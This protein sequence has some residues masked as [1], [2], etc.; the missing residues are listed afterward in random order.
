M[1]ENKPESQKL[2]CVC[3]SAAF[4][5]SEMKPKGT[6][7]ALQNR[8][9]LK[10]RVL[11]PALP[12]LWVYGIY[13]HVSGELSGLMFRSRFRYQCGIQSLSEMHVWACFLARPQGL[14]PTQLVLKAGLLRQ[15]WSHAV[16]MTDDLW[17][18]T[19]IWEISLLMFSYLSREKHVWFLTI[20][21]INWTYAMPPGSLLWALHSGFSQSPHQHS[22]GVV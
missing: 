5:S 2:S 18:L 12:A 3:S 11:S 6:A 14:Q 7:P 16:L 21:I 9:L 19:P 8:K 4:C 17:R 1:W 20:G 22:S 13:L 15:K 10:E